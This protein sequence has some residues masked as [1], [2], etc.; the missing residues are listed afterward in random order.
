MD[1]KLRKK[2]DWAIKF[3]QSASKKSIDN[4][5]DRIEV[6]YSGGKDSDVLL[7][8]VKL[9]GVPYQ[10]IYKCTTVDPPG[11][12]K[13]VKQVGGVE[14]KMPKRRF[15]E[16]VE[17]MGFPNRFVRFCC[18]FL[19]EYNIN[20]YLLVGVRRSESTRRSKIQEPEVCASFNRYKAVHRFMPMLDWNDDDVEMFIKE[21]GIK[22]HPLY[23]DDDGSFHVERRLGCMCCPLAG[24]AKRIEQFKQYPNM[25]K[26]YINAGKKYI[27]THPNVKASKNYDDVYEWFVRDVFFPKQTQKW[28]NKFKNGLFD[29]P[30]YKKFLEDYFNIKFKED[31]E[32]KE[33]EKQKE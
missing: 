27:A 21:R 14:I 17:Q 20:Q 3:I 6:G 23:Y 32:S 18:G 33:K 11:T 29:K 9:A 10:A 31:A 13:H 2:V 19:K 12:L 30:D 5:Q 22:C 25:V 8:L 1:D 24:R 28:E 26:A 16:L 4:G 15:F 7:E